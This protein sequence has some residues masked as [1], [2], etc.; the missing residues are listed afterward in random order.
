MFLLLG[1]P[2]LQA[3]AS[4]TLRKNPGFSPRG[5]LSIAEAMA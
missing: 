1:N 3:W 5:M 4:N 2:S